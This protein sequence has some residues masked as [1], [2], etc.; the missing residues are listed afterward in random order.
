MII[1]LTHNEADNFSTILTC[2]IRYGWS[3]TA[4]TARGAVYQ[5]SSVQHLH[6]VDKSFLLPSR[7]GTSQDFND[8]SHSSRV[9]ALTRDSLELNGWLETNLL[10]SVTIA[11]YIKLLS[12]FHLTQWQKVAKKVEFIFE[13][14]KTRLDSSPSGRIESFFESSHSSF[15][16]YSH[17]RPDTHT[18][19]RTQIIRCDQMQ[20]TDWHIKCLFVSALNSICILK[21]SALM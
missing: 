1:G 15:H 8:S 5:P 20:P 21:K 3:Q 16:R 7:G 9:S 10:F 17:H 14:C 4:H 19:S 2:A 11:L 18:R 13:S 12:K 6:I